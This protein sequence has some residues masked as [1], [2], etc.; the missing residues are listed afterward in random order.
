MKKIK[1]LHRVSSIGIGGLE[2]YV[3]N[4]YKNIDRDKFQFDLLTHNNEAIKNIAE[5][6]ELQMGVKVFTETERTNKKLLIKQINA[7]L[8]EGYDV[9]HM[10]TNY[11]VGFLIEEI[12]MQRKIPKVIVHSHNTSIDQVAPEKRTQALAIH[13]YYK[14]KFNKEHA[15]HFC[16]C[17]KLAAEWLYGPQIPRDE[18]QIIHNAIDISQYSYNVEKRKRAREEFDIEG[19]FVIGHIGRFAYQ[20]NHEFLIRVFA[21]SYKKNNKARLFL[22]GEGNERPNIE[23]MVEELGLINVV[24]FLGWRDD[25]NYL[26]QAMDIFVLPSR[27][28]GLP[29]TLIEAQ[30]AGLKCITSDCV[31]EEAVITGNLLRLPLDKEKWIEKIQELQEEYERKDMYQKLT[32]KGYNIKK[33]AKKMEKLYLSDP[34]TNIGLNRELLGGGG[35]DS[36]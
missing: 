23:K 35:I 34:C 22:V 5:V 7:I 16:A 2:T 18:I 12:A 14:E 27:F 24:S 1:V 21:E 9:I 8:E 30:A 32:E 19:C 28:E 33:E 36:L 11:W 15:T 31:T 26:M 10:N 4:Y 25:V 17:S 13:N 20:K 3:I 6:Q 29:V